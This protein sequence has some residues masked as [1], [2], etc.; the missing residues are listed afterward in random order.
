MIVIYSILFLLLSFVLFIWYTS[1]GKTTPIEGKNSIATIKSFTIGGMQQYATLRGVDKSKPV[2]LYLHG[3]PGFPEVALAKEYSQF[4]EENFVVVHWEQRGAGKSYHDNA[5]PSVEQLIED[6]KELSIL[7]AKEFNQEKIHLLGHSW[8]TFL[9]MLTL[10]RYPE[11]FHT[12]IGIGQVCNQYKAEEIS[13]AWI[14][15]Q[16]IKRGKKREIKRVATFTLPQKDAPISSWKS[17]MNKQ[18]AFVIH[19]GG[20]TY[21]K[22]NSIKIIKDLLFATE[23]TLSEKIKFIKGIG[24]SFDALWL[25]VVAVDLGETID[26]VDVPIYIFQGKH[27]YQT[28]T[29]VA[30]E[31]F[32]HI[33]APSKK[34][35][36]FEH[37][38]H[39]PHFEEVEK[40]NAILKEEIVL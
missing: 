23:Y 25:D 22:T 37:A 17:Y 7:L 33:E 31:F 1:R 14:K 8:G 9:G 2:L 40:F 30:K 26:K 19:Y 29:S 16:A 38:A 35:Y 28:A 11:L 34:F 10:H 36:L 15:E 13:L 6:T 20:S 39:S 4:L 21:E 24:A 3:G 12:Y 5:N 27:D 18:R 32:D